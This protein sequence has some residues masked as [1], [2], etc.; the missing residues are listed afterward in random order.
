MGVERALELVDAPLQAAGRVGDQ[1]RALAADCLEE[2]LPTSG[3]PPPRSPPTWRRRCRC[4]PWRCG[5]CC[6]TWSPTRW[7]RAHGTSMGAVASPGS[8]RLT[9]DDDGVGVAKA[10]RVCGGQ[11]AGSEPVPPAGRP[12]RRILAGAPCGGGHARQRGWLTGAGHDQRPDRRRPRAVP[13]RPAEPAGAGADITPVGEA[14]T[15]ERR[16]GR[17]APGTLPGPLDRRRRDSGLT[18]SRN[19]KGLAG[20]EGAGRLLLGRPQL[21]A[22]G[23]GCGSRRACPQAR[24]RRGAG[25]RHPAGGGRRRYVDPDL[26]AKLVVPDR[27]AALEPPSER[28]R[29]VLQLLALGYTNQEIGRKRFIPVRTVDTHRAHIMR[30]LG[31]R[32]A[33]RR[34]CSPSRTG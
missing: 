11:P 1:G 33:P 15:A 6:A 27:S 24:I 31:S 3:R 14:A 13:G 25:R 4:R 29:D 7:R 10:G 2:A 21:G 30:K 17:P 5:S 23:A 20:V 16:S 22:A 8:W 26:G 18:R 32:H 9:V 12:V 34:C 19:S 28:E